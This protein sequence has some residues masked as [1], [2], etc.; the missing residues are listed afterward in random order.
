MPVADLVRWRNEVESGAV[1]GPRLVVAGPFIDGPHP[2]WPGSIKVSTEEDGKQAVDTLKAA[3]RWT[4]WRRSIPPEE[5][6]RA[7]YFGIA[8]EAQKDGI[9]FVGHVPLEIG[10]DEASNAGQKSVEHLLGILFYTSSKSAELTVDL[11]KGTNSNLLNNQMVDTYDPARASA[12]FALFAKN[13][14][15]PHVDH[16]VC[17]AL[18]PGTPGI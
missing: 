18:P 1:L 16:S 17:P 2:I 3:F 6:P 14:A 11:M 7:A 10:V 15:G 4:F 9:P 13:L 5:V 8:K 12:L